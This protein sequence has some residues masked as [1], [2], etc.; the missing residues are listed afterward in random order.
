MCSAIPFLRG[1]H[2]S[3]IKASKLLTH[4]SA[5]DWGGC[6]CSRCRSRSALGN[7][8]RPL[9]YGSHMSQS[10]CMSRESR[11]TEWS[12]SYIL[13]HSFE[14]LNRW[15]RGTHAMRSWTAPVDRLPGVCRWC[16]TFFFFKIMF[17]R[18]FILENVILSPSSGLWW[19]HFGKTFCIGEF[20]CTP[21]TFG[22]WKLTNC[23]GVRGGTIPLCPWYFMLFICRTFR[24]TCINYMHVS[25][26]GL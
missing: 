10:F 9:L 14:I 19:R 26:N 22:I 25:L 18:R 11:E 21:S 17:A 24:L 12:L 23:G 1:W 15:L 13:I 5:G 16:E 2:K 4:V 7:W 8:V 20:R 3:N 6:F